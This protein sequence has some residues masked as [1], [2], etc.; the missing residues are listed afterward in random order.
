MG[1]WHEA[2]SVGSSVPRTFDRLSLA[3]DRAGKPEAAAE[4]CERG[5]ERFLAEGR[6]NKLVEQIEKRGQRCRAKAAS[7]GEASNSVPSMRTSGR[8]VNKG[9][10]SRSGR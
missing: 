5:M 9:H 6:R 2:T 7:L 1:L 3:L 8:K 10:L 4:V